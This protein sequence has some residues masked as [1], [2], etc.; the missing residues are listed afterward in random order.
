MTCSEVS[1]ASG[2]GYD[3]RGHG[4]DPGRVADPEDRDLRDPV[5]GVD[6]LLDLPAGEVLPTRLDHVL[7]PVDHE[8][9]AVVIDV[10]QVPGVEPSVAEASAVLASSW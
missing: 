8:Q 2:P 4:L 10:P 5:E 9:S 1:A 7:L 3:D 6:R